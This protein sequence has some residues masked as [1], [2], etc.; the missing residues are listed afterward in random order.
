MAFDPDLLGG[1]GVVVV[2][3]VGRG[4]VA[5]VNR[6]YLLEDSGSVALCIPLG[7]VIL[8]RNGLLA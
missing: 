2:S 1:G 3:G 4:V 6:G 7:R 8:D 5:A